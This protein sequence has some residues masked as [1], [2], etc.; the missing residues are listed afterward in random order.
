MSVV[1]FVLNIIILFLA[2]V[3]GT[4]CNNAERIKKKIKRM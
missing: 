1:K 2:C 4:S 3:I